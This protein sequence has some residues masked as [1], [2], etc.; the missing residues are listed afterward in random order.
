MALHARMGPL[1]A[2]EPPRHLP[3]GALLAPRAPEGILGRLGRGRRVPPGEAVPTQGSRHARPLTGLPLVPGS[4]S[5]P[6][7]PCRERRAGGQGPPKILGKPYHGASA[8]PHWLL[9]LCQGAPSRP[10]DRGD[11]SAPWQPFTPVASSPH[12]G[13]RL[14]RARWEVGPLQKGRGGAM[15]GTHRGSI[16]AGHPRKAGFPLGSLQERGRPCWSPKA[17]KPLPALGSGNRGPPAPLPPLSPF[18]P[19]PPWRLAVP[20]NP[21]SREGK[22]GV[23]GVLEAKTLLFPPPYT[24][25]AGDA[26]SGVPERL[27]I[28]NRDELEPN[29]ESKFASTAEKFQLG[30]FRHLPTS[31]GCCW[32]GRLEGSLANQPP[33]RQP[34]LGRG[35]GLPLAPQ[36]SGGGG[37]AF[38]R[39]NEGLKSPLV[40]GGGGHLLLSRV[41]WQLP[42]GDSRHRQAS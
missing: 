30:L 33:P 23:R 28:T 35:V 1:A 18:P 31:Q 26:V 25:R 39:A 27:R 34:L 38:S 36:A 2:T 14:R 3:P 37:Q 15:G 29:R 32:G 40:F 4:P 16:R 9:G 8:T 6:G 13:Q 11:P 42:W 21:G 10:R 22:R 7:W 41:L 19:E 17:G 24:Q 5:L 12:L 20:A